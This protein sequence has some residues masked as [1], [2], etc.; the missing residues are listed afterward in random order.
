M[1]TRSFL[2]GLGALGCLW[3]NGVLAT[4]G[5]AVR[6]LFGPRTLGGPVT[7]Q[8]GTRFDRGLVR[9]PSGEFLGL[10]R[11]Q[12]FWRAPSALRSA[13]PDTLRP[14]TILPPAAPQP[15]IS[16]PPYAADVPTR[17]GPPPRIEPARPADTW[18][19]TRDPRRRW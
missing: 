10:S 9:G 16:Y 3:A 8:P 19:R 4:E 2:L 14:T 13:V 6:G 5:T 17:F 12:R 11:E 1:R 18:L 7:P 15:V